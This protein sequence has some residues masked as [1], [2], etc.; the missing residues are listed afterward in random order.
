M[1]VKHVLYIG[2]GIIII[3]LFKSCVSE[4]KDQNSSNGEL[5][6]R[7]G[8]LEE[9]NKELKIEIAKLKGEN[10]KSKPSQNAETKSMEKPSIETKETLNKSPVDNKLVDDLIWK[11]KVEFENSADIETEMDSETLLIHMYPK[12][13][14]ANDLKILIANPTDQ[15]SV[16]SW[17][18]FNMH[19]VY[20]SA[21]FYEKTNQD[22]KFIIHDPN[23]KENIL[24]STHNN[25]EYKNFINN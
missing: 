19:L 13:D 21:T 9:E 23:D 25:Y 22:V 15:Q 5:L 17:T 2:L 12:N 4:P 14:F 8:E 16:E 18:D 7:V 3:L 10:N 20:I 1:K 6:K 24:F 11:A